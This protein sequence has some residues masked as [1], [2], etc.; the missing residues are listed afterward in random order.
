MAWRGRG[1]SGQVFGDVQPGYEPVAEMFRRQFADGLEVGAACAV[2]R[3]GRPVVDVWGGDRDRVR[4]LPWQRDTLVPVFS[5]TKGMA[6]MALAV[7]HS[8]EVL[9]FEAPVAA[10]WPD[11][12]TTARP[13]SPSGSCSRTGPGSPLWTSRSTRS[14]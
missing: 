4:R 9:D 8:Q 14:S 10:Y 1:D 5:T 3:D 13:R 6:S 11:S 12:P 7:A 2:F